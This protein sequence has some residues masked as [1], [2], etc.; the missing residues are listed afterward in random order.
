MTYALES[1]QQQK[2]TEGEEALR[3]LLERSALAE[4]QTV[5]TASGSEALSRPELSFLYGRLAWQAVQTGTGNFSLEDALRYWESASQQNPESTVYLNALAFAHYHL[6][7]LTTAKEIWLQVLPLEGEA[8]D[9]LFANGNPLGGRFP[10]VAPI[11]TNEGLT[12]S[13]GLGLVLWRLGI[14]QPIGQ[15]SQF[16]NQSSQLYHRVME[17]SPDSFKIDPLSQN[18]LWTDRAIQ[19]WQALGQVAGTPVP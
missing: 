17:N 19:D 4:A 9:P 16:L 18:W 5:L 11:P 6:G 14:A 10:E 12:A 2:W 8:N 3:S 7:H 13:A 1:L 15:Q